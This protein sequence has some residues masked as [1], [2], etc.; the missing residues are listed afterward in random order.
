MLTL[1]LYGLACLSAF[2]DLAARRRHGAALTPVLAAAGLAAHLAQM[3]AT[4]L[5][6]QRCP[7][8][9]RSEAL[10]LLAWLIIVVYLIASFRSR[11]TALS[12]T[13]PPAALVTLVT[14]NVLAAVLPP[15][16]LALPESGETSLFAVHVTLALV[17]VAALCVTCAASTLYL[18]QDRILKNKQHAA[19]LRALPPLE[20]LDRLASRSLAAGFPVLTLAIVSGSLLNASRS[21][22]FWSWRADEALAVAAWTIL[23]ASL[24]ARL[25]RGWHGRRSAWLAI[26]GVGAGVLTMIGM[27]L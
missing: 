9:A 20:S 18:I 3:I 12:A 24:W 21:G 17:G 22:Q 25:G 7:I 2:V 1:I 10:S 13:L 15:R 6:E 4:G 16:A 23:G 5:V 14:S 19:W 26:A 8:L 27:F 11:L